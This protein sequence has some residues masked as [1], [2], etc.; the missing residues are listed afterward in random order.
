MTKAIGQDTTVLSKTMEHLDFRPFFPAGSVAPT[1]DLA[2]SL[3]SDVVCDRLMNLQSTSFV[4]WGA[5]RG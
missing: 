5:E 4:A 1:R 3:Q 2:V